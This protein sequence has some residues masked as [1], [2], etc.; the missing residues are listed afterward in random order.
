MKEKLLIVTDLGRLKAYRLQA[1]PKFSHPRLELVDEWETDVAQHLSSEVTD[2]AGQ[3]R[4]GAAAP[5]PGPTTLSDAEPHNLDL[6]QRRRAVKTLASRLS[7]LLNRER[8]EECYLAADSRINQN[9]LK[10]WNPPTARKSTKS[11]RP[12]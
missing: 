3:I 9:L 7:Q 6:E 11:C 12:I 4:K 5:H 8:V 1:S 10:K 2:Q